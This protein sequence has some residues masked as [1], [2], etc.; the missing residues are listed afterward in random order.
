MLGK[1]KSDGSNSYTYFVTAGRYYE[2]Q[3]TLDRRAHE[4]PDAAD[5]ADAGQVLAKMV[6]PGLAH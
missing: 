2:V 5:E 1:N 4:G 3:I 6:V